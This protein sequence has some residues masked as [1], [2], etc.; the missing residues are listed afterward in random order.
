MIKAKNKLVHLLIVAAVCVGLTSPS[1]QA[2]SVIWQGANASVILGQP[3]NS[4]EFEN[5]LPAGA[6]VLGYSILEWRDA[7]YAPGPP[8]W[9]DDWIACNTGVPGQIIDGSPTEIWMHY[10][11]QYLRTVTTVA[12]SVVSVHLVGRGNDGRA[13]VFVD[14]VCAADLDMGTTG[15]Q[16]TV[17]VLIK[18]LSNT[19]HDIRVYQQGIGPRTNLGYD[20][21][22]LGAA[23]LSP[24]KVFPRFWYPNSVM[25]LYPTPPGVWPIYVP[26]GY[27][28]GWWWWH[29]QC[30][31][32]R[33]WYGPIGFPGPGIIGTNPSPAT[34]AYWRA[35]GW[36]P[37]AWYG[38][39]Y[40]WGFK[41]C[42]H[43]G[44]FPT[45]PYYTPTITWHSWFWDPAGQGHCLELLT[46]CDKDDPFGQS[47]MPVDNE[48]RTGFIIE[49]HQYS[50]NGSAV[51]GDFSPIT[52]IQTS[53]L[54]PY[55]GTLPGVT[56]ADI[57]AFQQSDIIQ[58]LFDGD[59][60]GEGYVGVQYAEW[61]HPE[62]Q[63]Q[64]S[65][66]SIVLIE[67]NDYTYDVNLPASPG[68]GVTVTVIPS[69]T[70]IAVGDPCSPGGY[71]REPGEPLDLYFDPT[72]WDI[73]QPVT[74]QA[75]DDSDSEND[76]VVWLSH[77]LDIDPNAGMSLSVTVQDNEC[78]GLGY[79]EA[80]FDR[81][82]IVD[83]YDFAKFAA[84]WLKSTE[85]MAP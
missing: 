9:Y 85:P 28:N 33:P 39:P 75:V 55:Y 78:G 19:I 49:A 11:P 31:W 18:N 74:V 20:V 42:L 26:H 66:W 71:M 7:D 48:I 41:K 29:H 77:S 73:P 65:T 1:A 6:T 16:Q 38:G 72:T 17:V 46:M 14:N 58:T 10:A 45:I 64:A 63:V 40:F 12:G 21:A 5:P 62:P 30:S 68:V 36:W 34:V 23:V 24:N 22:T 82:C 84:D 2:V 54:V 3:Y 8:Q 51:E 15:P 67:G 37:P 44:W 83:L 76:E 53:Q 52:Y 57:I 81:N 13:R 59:P 27:Y 80:D 47:V 60:S 70:E 79:A 4:L 50:V 43:Y 69:S 61:P 32:F 35:M 56:E 25:T